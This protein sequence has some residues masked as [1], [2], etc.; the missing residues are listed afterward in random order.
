MEEEDEY[1]LDRG[2]GDEVDIKSGNLQVDVD[3]N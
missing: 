3:K 2:D 1:K